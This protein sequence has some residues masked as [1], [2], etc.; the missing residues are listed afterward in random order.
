MSE[1]DQNIN[2]DKLPDNSDS[3][4]NTEQ[5]KPAEQKVKQGKKKPDQRPPKKAQP[6]R[7]IAMFAILLALIAIV[8]SSYIGWRGMPLEKK[9]PDLVDGIDLLQSQLA[10][11]QAKLSDTIA[12]TQPLNNQVD[13]LWQREQR[14]LGRVDTL[15]RKVRDLEGNSRDQWRL[16]EVEYLMRLA[17]QRLLM[18]ANVSSS[19]NL[20]NSADQ[21]LRELDDYSLFPVRE[22]LAEDMAALRSTA[23]F[24]KETTFLRLTTLSNLIPNLVLLDEQRLHPSMQ[25]V[26][27]PSTTVT[28]P[29]TSDWQSK[30]LDRAKI[31]LLKVWQGFMGLFRI[32]TDRQEPVEMLLSSEQELAVRQNL[33]LML[34]QAKLAILTRE[35]GIYQDSLEQAEQWLNRYFVRGGEASESIARELKALQ[36]EVI[37]PSLPDINRSLEALKSYRMDLETPVTESR[38]PT[39]DITAPGAEE[40]APEPEPES[41]PLEPESKPLIEELEKP[42][43]EPVPVESVESVS[44]AND[45][46]I[47][48]DS[49]P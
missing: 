9:Q 11:Q 25:A 17:N 27:A 21:I 7:G 16:A 12:S 28:E 4:A 48:E 18:G 33:R 41:E 40:L 45:A 13:E 39:P 36:T 22:A 42:A 31:A 2:S 6:G 15:S 49:T 26:D 3:N 14:L 46:D 29:E 20:L 43:I 34:E 30:M 1:P 24:D 32:N 19:Q 47:S 8:L 44:V 35:A 38:T 37:A 23:D 10:R 5:S